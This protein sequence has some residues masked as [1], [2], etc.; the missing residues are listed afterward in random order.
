MVLGGMFVSPLPDV[1]SSRIVVAWASGVT[2]VVAA[3][4]NRTYFLS[5]HLLSFSNYNLLDSKNTLQ[6]TVCFNSVILLLS[7]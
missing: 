3:T 6:V 7:H 5:N 2:A 4:G 1:I